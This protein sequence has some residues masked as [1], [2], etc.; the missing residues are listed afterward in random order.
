MATVLM[1]IENKDQDMAKQKMVENG[2][3]VTPDATK[4]VFEKPED[5][6]K[7][8]FADDGDDLPN[9]HPPEYYIL[10]GAI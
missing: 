6:F 8:G 2:T 7:D 3:D 5:L 9:K 10:H 1:T 4:T